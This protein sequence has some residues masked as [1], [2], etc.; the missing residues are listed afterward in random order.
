[1]S[2]EIKEV[3]LHEYAGVRYETSDEAHRAKWLDDNSVRIAEA[4]ASVV[5]SDVWAQKRL[6]AST[7]E[8]R[9]IFAQL[10]LAECLRKGVVYVRPL[11]QKVIKGGSND[12]S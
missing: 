4:C 5:N 2:L 3:T 11:N 10:V 1:M 6:H 8:G 9:D 12:Q 7:E